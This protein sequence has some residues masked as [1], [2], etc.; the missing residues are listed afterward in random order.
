MSLLQYFIAPFLVS[1]G[2]LF[3]II[4]LMAL[5]KIKKQSLKIQPT[6]TWNYLILLT[7]I[8]CLCYILVEY[9]IFQLSFSFQL[10][11][12]SLVYFFGALFVYLIT[13]N[14]Y[15]LIC[16]LISKIELS[17]QYAEN[18]RTNNEKETNE[19]KAVTEAN[20]RMKQ[21]Y[22]EV[23][24]IKMFLEKKEIELSNQNNEF[25]KANLELS[26]SNSKLTEAYA[27]LKEA[28]RKLDLNKRK[29]NRKNKYLSKSNLLMAEVF[30]KF[31][32]EPFLPKIM[33]KELSQ[34]QTGYI[35]NTNLSIVF[36]DIR[37]FTAIAENLDL[38]VLFDI[39]NRYF[40]FM[41]DPIYQNNG[42]I[43]QFVGDA[44]IA[45]FDED[46]TLPEK[47]HAVSAVTAALNMQFALNKFNEE[48][49]QILKKAIEIGIGI[50]T[51]EVMIGTVGYENRIDLSIL[52]N[53]LDIVSRIE[54]LTKEYHAKIII[55][56]TT[57]MN[58]DTSLFQ[59]RP[60]GYLSTADLSTIKI[61]ELFDCDQ[62]EIILKKKSSKPYFEK[63]FN[64]LDNNQIKEAVEQFKFSLEV[65]PEDTAAKF[66]LK[67]Y[68]R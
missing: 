25:V 62:T 19:N 37:S 28:K 11:L 16:L 51:G 41:S 5:I 33:N 50:H 31:I 67:K 39:L 43:Y 13:N 3:M 59:Y 66:L 8:F 53:T 44:I 68:D 57:F 10:L 12:I 54:L 24:K 9:D 46:K 38:R 1:V 7:V 61:F 35:E 15:S 47:K 55:S 48:N 49:V 21:L 27:E 64:F 32:P 36:S 40:S 17:K 2:L 30:K 60:I 56:E 23:E 42:F 58:L 6:R 52:G 20:T 34:I 4:S 63:A 26:Q 45:L 18:A 29:L 14:I 22:A 65:Y